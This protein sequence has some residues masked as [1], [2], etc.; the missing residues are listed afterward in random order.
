[1]KTPLST[2]R[3]VP[4]PRRPPTSILTALLLAVTLALGG[5]AASDYGDYDYGDRHDGTLIGGGLGV[6]AGA[7]VG[8]QSGHAGEGA[9]LGGL[10]GAGT[11]YAIGAE[12]DLRR[13]RGRRG[14]Y[15][16]AGYGDGY[17]DARPRRPA[18]RY[19]RYDYDPYCR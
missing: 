13:E 1:M 14:E 17:D 5:C 2:V 3:D 6:A 18:P 19:E 4:A 9:V 10:I 16:G 11:G 8:R 12:R 15:Y 7:I